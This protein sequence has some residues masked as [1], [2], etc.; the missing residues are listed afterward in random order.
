MPPTR[1]AL[2]SRSPSLYPALLSTLCRYRRRPRRLQALLK[3]CRS[4]RTKRTFL[5]LARRACQVRSSGT[6]ST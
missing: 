6:T 1:Q 5:L 4:V 3:E 2:P